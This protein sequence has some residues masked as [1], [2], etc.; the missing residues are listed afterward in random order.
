MEVEG[1]PS[2]RRSFRGR[3]RLGA[4]TGPPAGLTLVGMAAADSPGKRPSEDAEEPGAGMGRRAGYDGAL[5]F[6]EAAAAITLAAALAFA[7]AI[8]ALWVV[9][10]AKFGLVC[11]RL[12]AV[13]RFVNANWRAALVLAVP[14]FYRPARSFLERAVKMPGMEAEPPIR[15][16]EKPNP[17]SRD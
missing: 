17:P 14:L 4:L 16:A 1:R 13:A 12:A 7:A 2:R 11:G 8:A 3:G 6:F 5:A 9:W 10:P 15:G